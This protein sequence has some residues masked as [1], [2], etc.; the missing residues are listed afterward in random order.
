[1][2]IFQ[3]PLP[4]LLLFSFSSS[5]FSSSILSV[6]PRLS[7]LSRVVSHSPALSS[8]LPRLAANLN[9]LTPPPNRSIA[10]YLS[11]SQLD[12]DGASFITPPSP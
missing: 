11:L 8:R 1:M 6:L 9:L 10:Y 12:V 7:C 4:V 2:V 5:S 3:S